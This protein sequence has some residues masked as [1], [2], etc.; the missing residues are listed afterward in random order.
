MRDLEVETAR[1]EIGGD[2]KVMEVTETTGN[3]LS[4]NTV[5]L[6]LPVLKRELLL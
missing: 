4:R 2:A 6:R 1:F 5:H 3:T